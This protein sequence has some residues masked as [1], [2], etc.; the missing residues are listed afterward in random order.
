MYWSLVTHTHTCKLIRKQQIKQGRNQ[1]KFSFIGRG[2]LP[3]MVS[4]VSSLPPL[5]FFSFLSLTTP[6]FRRFTHPEVDVKSS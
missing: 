1:K 4:S 2:F 5:S 3:G 6:L